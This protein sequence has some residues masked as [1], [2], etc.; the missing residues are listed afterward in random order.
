ML[1]TPHPLAAVV[2]PASS[3]HPGVVAIILMLL[4][5]SRQV[6]LVTE[7]NSNT[8]S[9]AE[10]TLNVDSISSAD[11]TSSAN[12]QEDSEVEDSDFDSRV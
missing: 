11:S 9:I 5:I 10:S 12:Y 4:F 2:H 3:S 1:K 6:N 7:T 8:D